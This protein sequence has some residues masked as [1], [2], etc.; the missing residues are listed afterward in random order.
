MNVCFKNL[1]INQLPIPGFKH[2]LAERATVVAT[3]MVLLVKFYSQ[4]IS[5]TALGVSLVLQEIA[6]AEKSEL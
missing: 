2:S 3:G 5:I 1:F 4:L 6:M